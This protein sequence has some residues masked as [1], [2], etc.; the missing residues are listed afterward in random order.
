MLHDILQDRTVAVRRGAVRSGDLCVANT[1]PTSEND[2][3]SKITTIGCTV[4]AV[5]LALGLTSA[6][7]DG[8]KSEITA[9]AMDYMQG[10]YDANPDRMERAL[11][12]DLAKRILTPDPKRKH[13]KVDHMPWIVVVSHFSA[14]GV[15]HAFI[16][17]DLELIHH[18]IVFPGYIRL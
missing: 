17:S 5:G 2:E 14:R 18:V 9:T 12:P 13:G 6:D 3:M 1:D 4:L 10:W 15:S 8:E 7:Q 11:H 16:I